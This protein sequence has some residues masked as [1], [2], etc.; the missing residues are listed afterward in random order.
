MIRLKVPGPYL[1]IH[2]IIILSV[3][4]N[5][6]FLVTRRRAASFREG[7]FIFERCGKDIFYS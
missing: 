2:L 5:K 7:N 4:D 3:T 6:K 1:N